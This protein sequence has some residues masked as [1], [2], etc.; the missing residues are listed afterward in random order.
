MRVRG[1]TNV[2]T[3]V[4]IRTL[5]YRWT[6][7]LWSMLPNIVD[8]EF[9]LVYPWSEL[10]HHREVATLL[11]HWNSHRP[12]IPRTSQ[13]NTI[14]SMGPRDND[15]NLLGLSRHR[16]VSC[17]LDGATKCLPRVLLHSRAFKRLWSS[18][19]L[20]GI[21]RSRRMLRVG[22]PALFSPL[23]LAHTNNL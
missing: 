20:I 3:H 15:R 11:L 4:R 16:Q 14:T 23:R 9:V 13:L 1:H 19:V 8:D 7:L 5:P 17:E 21:P 18:R 12:T 2:R 10:L 22:P 6:Y